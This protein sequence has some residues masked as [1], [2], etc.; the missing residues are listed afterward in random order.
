MKG[1]FHDHLSKPYLGASSNEVMLKKI[2]CNVSPKR[3][4]TSLK[5]VLKHMSLKTLTPLIRSLLFIYE[6]QVLNCYLQEDF[7]RS[8]VML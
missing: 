3:A 2:A 4:L 6:V 1:E 7:F 8:V 5:R